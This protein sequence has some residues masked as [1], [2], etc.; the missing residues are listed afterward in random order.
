MPITFLSLP[1]ISLWTHAS[2]S[3]CADLFRTS[4]AGCLRLAEN[5]CAHVPLNVRLHVGDPELLDSAKLHGAFLNRPIRQPQPSELPTGTV[6]QRYLY[7]DPPQKLPGCGSW[8]AEREG[9][10]GPGGRP[11]R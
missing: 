1:I 8:L 3:T 4:N 11:E 5:P 9:A 10:R 6:L 7:H 2:A